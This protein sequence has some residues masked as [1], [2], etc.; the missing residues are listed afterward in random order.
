MLTSQTKITTKYSIKPHTPK[1]T[2]SESSPEVTPRASLVLKTF[3]PVSGVTLKYRTTK[4]QEVTRLVGTALGRLSRPM[5]GVANVPE[6][7]M[8]DAEEEKVEQPVQAP[9][10]G[11]KKKKGKK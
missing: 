3:D 10:G 5:A 1:P 8:A 11:K 7:E 6:E 2:E 9:T 4:A